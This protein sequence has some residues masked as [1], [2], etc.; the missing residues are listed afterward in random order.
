MKLFIFLTDRVKHSQTINRKEVLEMT[1]QEELKHIIDELNEDKLKILLVMAKS[2]MS[3]NE[4]EN[5]Q[6]RIDAEQG[7]TQ[8]FATVDEWWENINA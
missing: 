2:W 1:T 4:V 8:K 7:N 3:P 5:I 6:A